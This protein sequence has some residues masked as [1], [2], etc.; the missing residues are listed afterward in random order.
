MK[1]HLALLQARM[2]STR[3]PEK[4]TKDLEGKR[5]IDHMIELVKKSKKI[6]KIVLA[7]SDNK[8]D[9]IFEEI[10]NKHKIEIF[11]GSENDV[12]SRLYLAAKKH[13]ADIIIR[14]CADNLFLNVDLMDNMVDEL[15][16]KK[17]DYITDSHD[18]GAP[19][20]TLSEVMTLNALEKAFKESKKENEREHVTPYIREHPELF[21][22]KFFEVPL[23]L[24][25][26]NIRLTYDTAEDLQL[27]RLLY[28]K[29]YNEGNIDL[30]EVISY[31]DKNPQLVEMN[32]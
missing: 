19:S 3:L 22:I 27:I 6:D 13:N 4:M 21:N 24:K 10:C 7:T 2:Q 20:G 8:K 26:K 29:F 31:L 30:K 5:V 23:W 11:R 9:D 17:Y 15:I 32:Q 12:L 14:I 1:E 28:K 25:R 18:K 16:E